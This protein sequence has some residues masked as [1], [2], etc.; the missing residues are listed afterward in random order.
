MPV[1]T[2]RACRGLVEPQ[3]TTDST[4]AQ[5][6]FSS[7][8]YLGRGVIGGEFLADFSP[9]LDTFSNALF[10]QA[11]SVNSYMVNLIAAAPFGHVKNSNP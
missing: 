4:A 10:T 3:R 11:P 5:F 1:G 2:T 8:G 6:R 9:G 7:H